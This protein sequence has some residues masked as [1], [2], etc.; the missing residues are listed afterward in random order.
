MPLLLNIVVF[1]W[2]H[3]RSWR[4]T[5]RAP[6]SQTADTG[7]VLD[8][9]R[10][11]CGSCYVASTARMMMVMKLALLELEVAMSTDQSLTLAKIMM[12]MKMGMIPLLIHCLG[13]LRSLM[14]NS[15][16]PTRLP[17]GQAGSISIRRPCMQFC[18][19]LFS[20]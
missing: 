4:R 6:W 9:V 7:T 19:S 15:L 3:L 18:S 8:G 16:V 17:G 1:C 5:L 20:T 14:P 13:T 12:I 11:R 2:L 10:S